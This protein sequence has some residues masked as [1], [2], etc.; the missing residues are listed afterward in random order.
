MTLLDVDA[1]VHQL[2]EEIVAPEDVA[3]VRGS[4]LGELVLTLL[5]QS[6]DLTARAAGGGNEAGA[7]GLEQVAVDTRLV[8]I[9]LETGEAAQPEEVVHAGGVFGQHR[10]VR[11]HLAGVVVARTGERNALAFEPAGRREVGLHADDRLDAGG[12]GLLVEVVGAEHVA[13]VGHG[14]RRHLHARRLGEQ[15]LQAGRAVEH[16]VLGVHMQMDERVAA[17]RRPT[18]HALPGLPFARPSR[19]HRAVVRRDRGKTALPLRVHDH[20]AYLGGPLH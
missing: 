9:A 7:V 10:H 14:Q 13:V 3:I 19:S 16:R 17:T 8:V 1:M 5:K 11:V 18:R 2:A 20:H 6:V 15:V 4:L 12:L